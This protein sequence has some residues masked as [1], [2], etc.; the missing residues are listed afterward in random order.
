[1]R[2]IRCKTMKSAA[3]FVAFVLLTAAP[4]LAKTGLYDG[5]PAKYVFLFIGDGMGLP[6][7]AATAQFAGKTLV[8]DEFPAQG[9]TTTYAADRFITDSAAAGTAI[10]SGV[11][12]NCGMI[13][14]TPD[15]QNVKT[16]AEIAKENGMKVGIISSVSI[17]HATP[18][19]FYSHVKSRSMYHNIDHA[20]VESDFDFF[21]GGGLKDP[22]GKRVLKKDPNAKTLGDAIAKAKD[23]GFTVVTA[24]NDFMGLKPGSG[25]VLAYNDW[26]QDSGALPYDMDNRAEDITLPEFTEKAIELLDNDKGFFIMVEGGKIDWACHANDAVAAIKDTVAFDEAVQKAVAFAEKHPGE[27]LIVTTGDHECGGLTVGFAGTKYDSDFQVLGNQ[28]ISFTKFDQDVMESYK[29]DFD[30][31]KPVITE[32]F[33]LKFEGD[34]K[35]DPMVLTDYQKVQLQ[36]A[37]KQAM[38]GD[39]ER[40]AD[41]TTYLLYGGY[42]PLTV[43]ITHILNNKAGLAWTSY[44]HTAVPIGTSAMGVGED[45]FNGYYDNTDVAK[46]LMAVMGVDSKV[47]MA[48]N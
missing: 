25:K 2:T 34:P 35:S 42:N 31:I 40:A 10:A 6:Q 11:K 9:I 23:N 39:K 3:L 14:M 22:A 33:G 13:G 44:S 37:F 19:S 24:K 26:L 32:N 28:K 7:K 29:G 17:D 36:D 27:V 48:Q 43:Q 41:D 4:A 47:H 16:I 18:A 5:K 1:M 15:Q 46:K 30:G 21:G 38:L 8:M 45:S 12:T 20:L